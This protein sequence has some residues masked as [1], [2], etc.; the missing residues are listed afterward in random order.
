MDITEVNEVT[1]KALRQHEFNSIDKW[2]PYIPLRKS[3]IN[4]NSS[5]DYFASKADLLLSKSGY[6]VAQSSSTSAL[7]SRYSI[8]PLAPLAKE[9][10]PIDGIRRKVICLCP[11]SS[12]VL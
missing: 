5:D 12:N 10:F 1:P 6:I 4:D 7:D 2:K 9:R 11:I 3:S 8:P